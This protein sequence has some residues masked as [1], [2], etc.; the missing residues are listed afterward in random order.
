MPV[1]AVIMLKTVNLVHEQLQKLTNSRNTATFN[2][3]EIYASFALNKLRFLFQQYVFTYMMR[4]Q[5]TTKT[6]FTSIYL[7]NQNFHSALLSLMK[8]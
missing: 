5:I 7:K 1:S 2:T 3:K 4:I 8:S 6:I